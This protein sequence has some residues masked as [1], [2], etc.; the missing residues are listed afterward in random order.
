[1]YRPLHCPHPEV[2]G[3]AVR[4]EIALDG[5]VA[6]SVVA[7]SPSVVAVSVAWCRPASIRPCRRRRRRHRRQRTNRR[8]SRRRRRRNSAAVAARRIERVTACGVGAKGSSV[9]GPRQCVPVSLR[10]QASAMPTSNISFQQGR[11]RADGFNRAA[12]SRTRPPSR[13]R[14]HP[15][16]TPHRHRHP[17]HPRHRHRVRRPRHHRQGPGELRRHRPRHTRNRRRRL[18]DG[19]GHQPHRNRTRHRRLPHRGIE[20]PRHYGR[21]GRQLHHHQRPHRHDRRQRRR[22]QRR[23]TGP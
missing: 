16:R 13:P 14:V 10:S 17:R 5:R 19:P 22:R 2:T 11:R 6:G 3:S 9:D 15:R 7:V 4:D 18:L 23:T 21:P 20:P 1:M 8:H 12:A